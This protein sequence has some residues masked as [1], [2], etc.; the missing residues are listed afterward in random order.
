MTEGDPTDKLSAK[1]P[2]VLLL[3]LIVERGGDVMGEL[4][5]PLSQRR[6]RF[7]GRSTITAALQA[8]IDE[9]VSGARNE[10]GSQRTEEQ[11]PNISWVVNVQVDGRAAMSASTPSEDAEAVESLEVTIAPGAAG[12]V[13]DLMPGKGTSVKLIVIKSSFYSN[14]VSYMASDG[15]TD[16]GSVTL[17][18]PQVYTGGSVALFGISPNQL[19]F[20]NASTTTS[21]D[22]TIL[23]ARD[24]TP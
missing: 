22:V 13:V 17:S 18:A 8:W 11:M 16:S 5:D 19:K 24:A 12:M 23:V 15:K 3:R 9:V 10:S 14:D 1:R 4:V 21:A 6:Q 7:T 2:F 20:T